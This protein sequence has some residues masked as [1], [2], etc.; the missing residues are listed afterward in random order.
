MTELA[1]EAI[2]VKKTFGGESK[3][4]LRRP[5]IVKALDGVDFRI[6]IGENGEK[7]IFRCIYYR[8]R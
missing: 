2:K 4:P 6:K 3:G 1:I 5:P 8:I 7:N